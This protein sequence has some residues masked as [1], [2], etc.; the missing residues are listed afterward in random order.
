MH[1]NL[2][3]FL[4][5]LKSVNRR[6]NNL[7][8]FPRSRFAWW[9]TCVQALLD[10]SFYTRDCGIISILRSEVDRRAHGTISRNDFDPRASSH[11]MSRIHKLLQSDGT[12]SLRSISSSTFYHRRKNGD[13]RCHADK[14]APKFAVVM[15]RVNSIPFEINK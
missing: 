9:C 11:D 2:Y 6:G 3:S 10:L 15:V 7:I 8:Q 12:R 13:S 5:W 14:F 1:V 4:Q